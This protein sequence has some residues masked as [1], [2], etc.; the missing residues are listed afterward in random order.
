MSYATIIIGHVRTKLFKT[1]ELECPPLF[2][3]RLSF[4]Y[5][6]WPNKRLPIAHCPSTYFNCTIL[7]FFISQHYGSLYETAEPEYVDEPI[8]KK[9]KQN[10]HK[11]PGVPGADYPLY[12]EVPPTSFSCHNVPATP[13][14]YA[15]TE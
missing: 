2:F 4:C 1:S 13:G 8:P 10:L 15:N 9:D 12:H 6:C 3:A 7:F 11:I 5:V 14:M